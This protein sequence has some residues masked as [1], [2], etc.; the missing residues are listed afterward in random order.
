MYDQE[1]RDNMNETFVQEV[2][3]PDPIVTEIYSDTHPVASEAR[4][5]GLRAG[6]SLTLS[7]GWDFYLEEHRQAAKW[8]HP[9]SE[10]VCPGHCLSCGPWNLLMNLNAKVNIPE[11]REKAKI[12][13]SFAIELCWLQ[14][15]GH[16]HFVLENPLTSA[17][18]TLACVLDLLDAPG[19]F[20]V[21]IDQCMFGL[22]DMHG[23]PHRKATRLATSLQALISLMQDSRCDGSHQHAPVIGGS[24][25]TRPAGHYPKALAAAL[26][27]AFKNQFDF[28]T[29]L[30]L[31]P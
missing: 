1:L 12:L 11:L 18:W 29:R 4:R 2:D 7:T 15:K 5:Q 27:K 23:Q 6:E 25:I 13:V 30:G 19:V 14:I 22:Q 17:A 31:L 8:P 26:V 9:A 10:A 24:Q 20:S 3:F 28:E 16:R 21:V